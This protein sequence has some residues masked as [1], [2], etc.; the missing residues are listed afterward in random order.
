MAHQPRTVE[1]R[2]A[3]LAAEEWGVFEDQ[4]YMRAELGEL[5]A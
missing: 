4:G 1:E 2:V 3:R 5:L